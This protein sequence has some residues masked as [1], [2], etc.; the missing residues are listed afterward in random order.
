MVTPGEPLLTPALTHEP[1]GFGQTE[2]GMAA[3]ASKLD[4]AMGPTPTAASLR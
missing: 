4:E 2:E 1:Q 3:Q